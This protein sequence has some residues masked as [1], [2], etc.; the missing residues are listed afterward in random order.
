[1]DIMA[2]GWFRRAGLRRGREDELVSVYV[3]CAALRRDEVQ[4]ETS[5]GAG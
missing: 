4:T 2:T 3:R 1:M 5:R